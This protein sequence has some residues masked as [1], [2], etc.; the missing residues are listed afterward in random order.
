LNEQW[1]E[2]LEKIKPSC[3][4]ISKSEEGIL[5]KP[6]QMSFPQFIALHDQL[7][8]AGAVYLLQSQTFLIPDPAS[9]HL[10][11]LRTIFKT[12]QA[13]IR[14]SIAFLIENGFTPDQ[15]SGETGASLTTIY[16]YLGKR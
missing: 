10:K 3:E 13:E 6:K 14:E 7:I 16:R 8:K 1:K 5:V 15:I 11:K 12:S 9:P 2:L 4:S